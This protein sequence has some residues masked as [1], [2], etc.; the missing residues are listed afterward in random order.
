M[1]DFFY[2]WLTKYGFSESLADALS[3]VGAVLLIIVLS[4]LLKLLVK[5]VLLRG[6]KVYIKFSKNRWDDILVKRRVFD[7]LANLAPAIVIHM[8]ASVFPEYMDWIQ[9]LAFTYM[10]VIGLLI[11]NPL[12]D[13]VD[14]IYRKYEVSKEKPIKGFLQVVKIILFIVGGIIV[15]AMLINRSPWLLLSG[16]GALTAVLLLVFQNSLL[17]LVAGIQLT[18]NDMV[19]LGDWIEMPKYD[20]DGDVVDITLHTVKVQNWDRTITTIPSYV[21]ISDSFKNWRGMQQSGGRR[22]KRSIHIDMNSI[23]FCS[24]EMLQRFEEIH[25]LTEY[26]RM[27]R[28]EISDYNHKHDIDPSELVNGRHMTNIGTFRAYI[29]AYLKAHPG[30][31]HQMILMVRQLAPT[32]HG[33]PIEIYAFTNDIEWIN[34]ES[35]QADIFDHIFSIVP[36]FGLKVYQSP[37][38]QDFKDALHLPK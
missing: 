32:Q 19:R 28:D 24:E 30:I 17:G 6:I 23:Q 35:I 25:Y 16:I 26:I 7:R 34:Y 36:Q 12:L 4:A 5:H 1:L 20:A 21:L 10:V 31:H 15:I 3:V 33:L 2:Y 8:F 29:S 18:T 37:S 38:G 27:K 14:D 13:S 11:L 22:I 9:R